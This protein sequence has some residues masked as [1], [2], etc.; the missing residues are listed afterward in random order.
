MRITSDLQ[1]IGKRLIFQRPKGELRVTAVL[2]AA[3]VVIEEVRYEA[4]AMTA[5]AQKVGS[6]I[7]AIYQYCRA[8]DVPLLLP[9]RAGLAS[10]S[11]TFPGSCE[12]SIATWT[13]ALI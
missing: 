2:N 4:A 8:E 6:S 3:A 9:T 1:L 5:I 7:G 11:D 12:H 13:V 10:H